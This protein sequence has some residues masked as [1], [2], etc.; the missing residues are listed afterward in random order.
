MSAEVS[1]IIVSWNTRDILLRCLGALWNGSTAGVEA[2]VVDNA[3]TDGTPEAVESEFRDRAGL[4]V[5]RNNSN[6]GFPVA[7][8]Q[9]LEVAKAP[10]VLLLNPD[11]ILKEGT[12]DRMLEVLRTRAEVGAVGPKIRYPEGP[13]QYF[14]ARRL[15][16]LLDFVASRFGLSGLLPRLG[17][18][19][20]MMTDWDHE[21][22]RE[23]EGLSGS[24]ILMRTGD[25]RA[26]GGLI[27]LMYLEDSEVCWQVRHT[28]GKKVY[29]LAGAEGVHHHSASYSAITDSAHYLWVAE[30]LES[31]YLE[32]FVLHSGRVAVAA[33]RIANVISGALKLLGL[34]LA[35]PVAAWHRSARA[36]VSRALVRAYVRLKVG[37][38]GPTYKRLLDGG[39]VPAAR[40]LGRPGTR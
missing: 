23:V 2:I 1:A 32:F 28:L 12:L 27:E 14:C 25:L 10:Y 21:G 13:I 33:G 40:H 7:V 17:L 22:S 37:L 38:W 26:I 15:P 24:C 39:G 9:G 6:V 8:N 4:R 31:A 11:M 30:R 35:F 19:N 29:Y 5:I 18:R 36:R 20:Q 34:G 3:S 16:S